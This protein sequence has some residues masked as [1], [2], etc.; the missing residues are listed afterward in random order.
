MKNISTLTKGKYMNTMKMVAV[1]VALVG[2]ASV[3]FAADAVVGAGK[4][5]KMD[6]TLTVNNEQV[7]TS[8]GKQPLEIVYGDH[9]IIPGLEKGIEGMKVGEEKVIEVEPKDAYGEV[10]QKA[11]KEFP[12]SS[13]PKSPEPKVGMVLQ[14]ESPNGES[15]PAMIS[16]INGD[17]VTL[18]FNHPL[19]GKKLSFKIKVLDITDAPAV[20]AAS[21]AMPAVPTTP[22]PAK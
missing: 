8:V 13:M 7:E 11:F 10:D 16:A 20:P 6:Y 12:K 19:A 18:D 4:K 15:F 17:K 14:A 2:V 9:S 3:S 21:A 5:V 22:A 1:A